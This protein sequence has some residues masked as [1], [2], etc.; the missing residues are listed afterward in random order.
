MIIIERREDQWTSHN[1]QYSPDVNN[2]RRNHP[3]SIGSTISIS[4]AQ[5]Y[6]AWPL[7]SSRS[8]FQFILSIRFRKPF[9]LAAKW[10]A[11][12]ENNQFNLNYSFLI[13]VLV[14]TQTQDIFQVVILSLPA[15][16]MILTKPSN[17]GV[18]NRVGDFN[19]NFIE[20]Y[21]YEEPLPQG[22]TRRPPQ[23]EQENSFPGK[24]RPVQG[25]LIFHTF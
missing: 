23:L 13:L 17:S 12:A 18:R 2:Y 5:T 16:G 20:Y 10:Y 21:D 15:D 4:V 22:P 8:I 14:T 1:L 9:M 24:G 25:E 6:Q 3:A 7:G 11:G 19:P